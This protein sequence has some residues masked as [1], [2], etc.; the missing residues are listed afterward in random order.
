MSSFLF[1][2]TEPLFFDN[3]SDL[4]WSNV[5]RLNSR[6]G[7]SWYAPAYD[8]PLTSN[9]I[10]NWS[11]PVLVAHNFGSP[12]RV[13]GV[14]S[15]VGYW[16][17][18][19]VAYKGMV[20]TD[21]G[22]DRLTSLSLR[23]IRN[24]GGWDLSQ[25]SL[26]NPTTPQLAVELF[27]NDS[28]YSYGLAVVVVSGSQI[29]VMPL[30]R[31]DLTYG[32]F[33]VDLPSYNNT[34]ASGIGPLVSHVAATP[35]GRILPLN[36]ETMW[37]GSFDAIPLR[38]LGYGY[39]AG[40]AGGASLDF[41]ASAGLRSCLALSS[42]KMFAE[43]V[44]TNAGTFESDDA[45]MKQLDSSYLIGD[46]FYAMNQLG[47]PLSSI[48]ARVWPLP[49]NVREGSITAINADIS[50]QVMLNPFQL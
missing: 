29:F 14:T 49:P 22:A 2:R 18:G 23:A 50:F 9:V 41:A 3:V 1:R 36:V 37:S 13:S 20:S 38:T 16:I 39:S 28:E 24:V 5:F 31:G 34:D 19:L 6:D 35:T 48:P 25:L 26:T 21:V 33:G 30:N 15:N 27:Q 10:G 46:A 43:V 7:V 12:G 4:T 47:M 11:N 40:L 45:A 42:L 44:P 32:G 17:A 8:V